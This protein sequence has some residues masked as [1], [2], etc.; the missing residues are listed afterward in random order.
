MTASAVYS[1]F[2]GNLFVDG[3]LFGTRWT[4]PITYSF[5]DDISD[6]G[7]N[8]RFSF[9]GLNELNAAQQF[10]VR[11]ILGDS[12]PSAAS[13][14]AFT[15]GSFTDVATIPLNYVAN[16]TSPTTMVLAEAFSVSD[17]QGEINANP[18]PTAFAMFPD[19]ADPS[20]QASGDVIF[21][22]QGGQYQDPR[23]GNFAWAT[24]IHEIGHALGL[25]HGHRADHGLNDR[26]PD[27]VIPAWRNSLDYSVMTYSSSPNVFL[28]S[29]YQTERYGF[30]QTLMM[31]D[32]AALQHLYGA[33]FTT[34]ATNT[35]YSWSTTTGEMFVNGVGQGLPGAGDTSFDSNKIFLTIW[36]GG[37]ID[38][39]DMSNYSTALHIDLAPGESSRMDP[40]QRAVTHQ[41]PIQV[42]V[43]PGEALISQ[44]NVF[45]AL[46]YQG[47]TR[48]LI[49]NANGGSGNDWIDG[50][51][52]N[53]VLVGNDGNDVLNGREGSDVLRGGAGNDVLLGD[54]RSVQGYEGPGF[55]NVP[56]G[57]PINTPQTAFDLTPYIGTVS[58]PNV[59]LSDTNP[60]VSA[61]VTADNNGLDAFRI[62]VAAPGIMIIDVDN[63]SF[64]GLD[65]LIELF[66]ANGTPLAASDESAADPG[67]RQDMTGAQGDPGSEDPY[68]SFGINEPGWYYITVDDA[69]SRGVFTGGYT[70]SITLPVL[71]EDLANEGNDTLIGGSGADILRGHGGNDI[72][73]G[74]AGA[75]DMDGGEGYDQANYEGSSSAVAVDLRNGNAIGGDAEG[76]TLTGIEALVGSA[77]FDRLLGN[78]VANILRGE[79]GWDYLRGF[80]GNDQLF[81]GNG[82]DELWGDAGND[83]LAGEDGNDTL[84]GGANNDQLLGGSGNDILNGGAGADQVHGGE[85]FDQANYE[86]STSAV[87]VDLRNG[88]TIGGDAQGDVLTGIEALV[89]SAYFDTLLGNAVA[90]ILRGENGFDTLYGFAGNDRLYGGNGNDRLYGGTDDDLLYGGS[91][92]DFLQG[93][94]G[95]D[96]VYGEDGNDTFV[97]DADGTNDIYG[98]GDGIDTVDY[99]TATVGLSVN[100][101]NSQ[102]SSSQ[103]GTDKLYNIERVLGGSGNDIITGDITTR[104][105]SGNGGSDLITGGAGDNNLFGGSG[106]DVLRGLAGFDR[107]DGG[108][109]NDTLTGGLNGDTFVFANGFGQDRIT[110][111]EALNNFEKIDLS[112]VSAITSFADLSANHLSQVGANAV[113]TDGANTITLN[114]VNIADLDANDFVF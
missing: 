98:G 82:N 84:F 95:A 32:I 51:Q 91:G 6:F 92:N 75:D 78:G 46:L 11:Y 29:G 86:G 70:L 65:A 36:D 56:F 39:Y 59:F 87:A 55:V 68:I 105:L 34:N 80:G 72:L 90:N 69:L 44:G 61:V 4:G 50:N 99:S 89:G 28:R 5:A 74:G 102:A 41:R 108:T 109:G 2:T 43:E 14:I 26:G 97:G 21:G 37:G 12:D 40:A 13:P 19:P 107:L 67:S 45:N 64:Q 57:Q 35:V 49:E 66:D 22:T 48:S 85:G 76:D 93:G 114:N 10:A 3:V 62:Y 8:Y 106:G 25:K 30:P 38:T 18:I 33:D 24:H 73:N 15:Y 83:R 77:Y 111:F 9:G 71:F 113:I 54:R 104:L 47:D 79:N 27:Y 110:D 42:G 81:G 52:A 103:I 7:P 1:T 23:A 16:P 94:N 88:N 20:D 60:H 31:L 112:A 53:N 63:A 96:S 101:A 17:S 58:S 100:L